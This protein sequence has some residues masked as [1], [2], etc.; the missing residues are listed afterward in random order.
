MTPE[1]T[2][3]EARPQ[4]SKDGIL[5]EIGSVRE[6]KDKWNCKDRHKAGSHR[7]RGRWSEEVGT[8]GGHKNVQNNVRCL[9]HEALERLRIWPS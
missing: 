8:Q 1:A 6:S 9:I 7:S 3:A 4:C 2:T 5:S